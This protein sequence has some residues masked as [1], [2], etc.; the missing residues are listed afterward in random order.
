M[1]CL[2]PLGILGY[3]S[4]FGEMPFCLWAF[5]MDGL[6][7]PVMLGPRVMGPIRS[8]SRLNASIVVELIFLER[9]GPAQILGPVLIL[10]FWCHVPTR[11]IPKNKRNTISKFKIFT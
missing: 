6:N 10:E 8:V 7:G 4:C 11:V 3:G 9:Y 1:G 5:I 2:K